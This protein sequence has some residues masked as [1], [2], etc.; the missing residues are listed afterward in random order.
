ML[1]IIY[2]WYTYV[3]LDCSL[4]SECEINYTKIKILLQM[5]LCLKFAMKSF[6]D[7]NY[8]LLES[9]QHYDPSQSLSQNYFLTSNVAFVAI[10]LL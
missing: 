7:Q 6:W 5:E 8:L 3:Y 2:G 9:R 1:K 10:L 4:G